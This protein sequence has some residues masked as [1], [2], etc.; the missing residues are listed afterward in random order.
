MRRHDPIA[1]DRRLRGRDR[2]EQCAVGGIR[3][4]RRAGRF[5]GPRRRRRRGVG[6]GWVRATSLRA[7]RRNQ[8]DGVRRGAG[9]G[10][11]AEQAG[12]VTR[13]FGGQSGRAVRRLT[14]RGDDVFRSRR[15][16]GLGRGA[17][18]G[19][20]GRV[21][22]AHPDKFVGQGLGMCRPLGRNRVQRLH[23][24]ADARRP[25]RRWPAGCRSG[26]ARVARPARRLPAAVTMTHKPLRT[27]RAAPTPPPRPGL[28]AC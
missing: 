19:R 25:L 13:H 9:R 1:V 17:G 15:L 8:R 7:P 27:R 2:V 20:G 6:S 22:S 10:D 23:G 21:R 24:R 18:R 4:P 12:A 3:R 5:G 14:Q 28:A 26:P 16:G 11:R